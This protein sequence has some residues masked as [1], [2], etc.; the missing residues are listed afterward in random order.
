M[1]GKEDNARLFRGRLELKMVFLEKHKK[2]Q[3]SPGESGWIF[4][5]FSRVFSYDEQ[6]YKFLSLN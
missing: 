1:E 4:L 5:C 2:I 3:P 6:A